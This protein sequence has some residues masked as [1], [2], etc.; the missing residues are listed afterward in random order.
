[1]TAGQRGKPPLSLQYF[2]LYNYICLHL[3][4]SHHDAGTGTE[5]LLPVTEPSQPAPQL[6][7]YLVLHYASMIDGPGG[8]VTGCSE[9]EVTISRVPSGGEERQNV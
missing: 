3:I 4:F 7:V 8:L 5:T 2:K 6:T 1:M 9:T